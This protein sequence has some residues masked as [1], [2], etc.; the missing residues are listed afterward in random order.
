MYRGGF[1][2]DQTLRSS[3]PERRRVS[4]LAGEFLN[5]K[6][7]EDRTTVLACYGLRTSDLLSFFFGLAT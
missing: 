6:R 4:R 1:K 2:L 7:F 5:Y 3:F